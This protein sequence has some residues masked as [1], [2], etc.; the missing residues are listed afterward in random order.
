MGIFTYLL[1]PPLSKR[2]GVVKTMVLS[3]MG[4][5]LCIALLPVAPTPLVA[6]LLYTGWFAIQHISLPLRQSYM[7]AVLPPEER[8]STASVVQLSHTATNYATGSLAPTLGGY[9]LQEV[10]TTLPLFIS[11]AFFTVSNLL[12]YVFFGRIKPPEEDR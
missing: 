3:R 12:F 5:V 11:A 6:E 2:L 7:M 1:G 8:A 9:L 4:G 10:S